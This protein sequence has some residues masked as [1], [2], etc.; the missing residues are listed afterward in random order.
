KE[1]PIHLVSFRQGGSWAALDSRGRFDAA[2]GGDVSGLH[3]VVESN[4]IALN[5]LKERYYDPGLLAKYT[6][7][8]SE[9]L[10]KVESFENVGLFPEAT[11][12]EPL[13]GTGTLVIDLSNRGGGIGKVQVFVNDKELLADARGPAVAARDA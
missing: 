11:L 7:F 13:P 10:R 4:P 9:P 5:Q 6:G 12:S 2:N 3:W 1:A 8:S